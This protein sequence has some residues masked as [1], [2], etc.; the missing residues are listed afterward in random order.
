LRVLQQRGFLPAELNLNPARGTV[1]LGDIHE[2]LTTL[3]RSPRMRNV[4]SCDE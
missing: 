2:A 1:R 3:S 4:E